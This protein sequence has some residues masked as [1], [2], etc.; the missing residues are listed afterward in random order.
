MDDKW[1]PCLNHL[2]KT[3]LIMGLNI[4]FK[5]VICQ[6]VSELSFLHLLS[7]ALLCTKLS[8][9]PLFFVLFIFSSM[10]QVLGPISRHSYNSD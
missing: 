8:D 6:I 4:L 3:I 1:Q 5:G 7:G 9:L 10:I 2:G